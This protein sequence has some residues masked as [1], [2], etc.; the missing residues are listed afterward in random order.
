MTEPLFV[1][2]SGAIKKVSPEIAAQSGWK[3][4]QRADIENALKVAETESVGGHIKQGA[5]AAA[6]GAFDAVTGIPRVIS[7]GAA[8]LT[9]GEDMLEHVS[10]DNFLQDIYGVGSELL[11]HNTT[12]DAASRRFNQQRQLEAKVNPGTETGAYIGGQVAGA[13]ATGGGSLASEAGAGA[14]KALGGGFLARQAGRFATGFVEGAPL[15]MTQAQHDAYV[16]GRHLTAEQSVAAAGMSGVLGGGIVAGAGAAGEGLSKVFGKVK[17]GVTAIADKASDGSFL[18]KAL[19]TSDEAVGN[20]IKSTL[21]EDL[22]SPEVTQHVR[23]GFNGKN[24]A[25]VRA[26]TEGAAAR[27]MRS[28]INQIETSTKNLTPEWRELKPGNVA[29]TIATDDAS[30]V[31]QSEIVQNRLATIRESIETMKADPIAYGERAGINKLENSLQMAE[32]KAAAAIESGKMENAFTALD[33]LKRDMGPI[34]RKN[35]LISSDQ[36]AVAEVRN[37]YE[38]LR[39]DLT[40]DAWGEAGSMQKKTNAAFEDW[41]GTKHLFDRQ[42]LTE[43]GKEGWQKTY[44]ADP[45]K[46]E[47]WVSGLGQARNDLRHAIV[48]QHLDATQNLAKALSEA[49]ELT[50]AK[51]AELKSIESAA[52]SVQ[53]TVSKVQKQVSAVDQAQNFIATTTG[54]QG[55]FSGATIAGSVVGG[56]PG[57]AVGMGLDAVMNPG[58]FLAQRMKFEAMAVKSADRLGSGLDKFFGGM[59]G[60]AIG[61]K[62]GEIA[63]TAARTARGASVPSVL[64][65][66][67]TIAKSPELAFEKRR[68]EVITASADNNGGVRSAL[69]S[70]YGELPTQD[71]HGFTGAVLTATNALDFLRGKMPVG[72]PDTESYTPMTTQ[73]KPSKVE[74]AEWAETWNAVN[75]PLSII[76]AIGDGDM[77]SPDAVEAVQVVYPRMYQQWQV[78]TMTR[79]RKMDQA[80]HEVPVRQRMVLDTLLN[81]DGAGE[82]TFAPSFGAKWG[83]A[84]GGP[85]QNQP[86]PGRSGGAGGSIGKSSRTQTLAMI[87]SGG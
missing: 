33:T 61:Q 73:L 80:G 72:G 85:Q 50:P 71:P 10:G 2:E 41:L 43:T 7:A 1:D 5:K 3:P 84:I 48:E 55:V 17:E 66:F 18:R 12:A 58:K 49:G 36:A 77:P 19:G 82:P 21:G 46:L 52:K 30:K 6:A 9:G 57:A 54:S 56:L 37:L 24:L 76:D 38:G 60:S 74:I 64:G 16:E 35:A 81:L 32:R 20:T 83:Q 4:A 25:A 40:H 28:S 23:D 15:G 14:T 53:Q 69:A 62:A 26:D 51:A 59:S 29:K 44:G 47:T 79:I 68:E 86:P 11:G 87:G 27:E 63:Q 45:A 65:A 13:L 78:E 31:A 8:A 67:G 70:Q 34:G 75:D 39:Q 22:V 42:F